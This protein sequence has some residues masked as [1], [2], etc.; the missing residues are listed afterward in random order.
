MT[1]PTKRQYAIKKNIIIW[2]NAVCRGIRGEYEDGWSHRELF[3][4][5]K[6]TNSLARML[7]QLIGDK[8]MTNKPYL[9]CPTCKKYPKTILD[10]YQGHLEETRIW[11]N[12]CYELHDNNMEEIEYIELC[13]KCK[14]TLQELR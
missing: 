14:T 1:K 5:F 9:Y 13:A 4:D 11:N 2:F 7:N 10:H 8:T 12:D 3:K 6:D